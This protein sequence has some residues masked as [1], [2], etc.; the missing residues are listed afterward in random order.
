MR[1]LARVGSSQHN[2]R[3][4]PVETHRQQSNE[5][6]I[7]DG[8]MKNRRWTAGETREMARLEAQFKVDNKPNI[9]MAL[10]SSM[11]NRSYDA[12]KSYRRA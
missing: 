3:A 1:S 12:I 10:A 8:H 4:H 7:R 9:I 5:I 6:A 11:P 2:R